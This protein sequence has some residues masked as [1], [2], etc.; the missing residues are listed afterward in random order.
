M[1]YRDEMKLLNIKRMT[2]VLI[3]IITALYAQTAMANCTPTLYPGN[4]VVATVANPSFSTA[5]PL[6]TEGTVICINA[7]NPPILIE[8]DGWTNGHDGHALC[9]PAD[10]NNTSRWY[11]ECNEIELAYFGGGT[12]TVADPYLIT[13]PNHLAQLS[14][15]TDDLDKHY[16]LVN[17]LD[18]SNATINSIGSFTTPFTGSLDGN[19]KTISNLTISGNG[20][21]DRVE[22]YDMVPIFDLAILN[23]TV[24]GSS[25]TGG[26]VGY[27]R[28]G[29]IRNCYF[30]GSVSGNRDVGGLVG[31]SLGFIEDCFAI[32]EVQ[33]NRG[34]GGLVGTNFSMIQKCYASGKVTGGD[35]CGGLVGDT[36][37]YSFY[38][39]PSGQFIEIGP[40][41][42]LNCY[43]TGCVTGNG[44]IGGLIGINNYW[45]NEHEH[46]SIVIGSYSTG[47][48]SGNTDVGGLVGNGDGSVVDSFW[49]TCTSGISTSVG[50][51]GKTTAELKQM[52]TFTGPNWNFESIWDIDELMHYPYFQKP[53]ISDLNKDGIVNMLDLAIMAG[54][55]L[56]AWN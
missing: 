5:L 31:E 6:G 55:W 40:P 48:V 7:L 53:L 24:S 11:V 4:R 3:L 51:V 34:V 39:T 30:Q 18:C 19:H 43:A 29:T 41:T 13:E 8:W 25:R 23:S 54:E 20:L 17:D 37:P 27:L 2:I 10:P 9:S 35:R 14:T 28:A 21:F 1:E 22:A 46:I 49:D 36:E 44:S 33:G 50:G 26:L 16:K 38:Q 56:E 12:G 32:A 52:S 47:P 45:E 15:Y 42:I